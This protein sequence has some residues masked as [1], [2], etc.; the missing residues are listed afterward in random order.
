MKPKLYWIPGTMCDQL[1]WSRTWPELEQEFELVHLTIPT[2]PS[3]DDI[4]MALSAQINESEINLIGFSLGGYLATCLA[5]HFPNKVANLLVI[6]NS[7][8]P[9]PEAEIQQRKQTINWLEKFA[10]RGVTEQKINTMLAASRADDIG[11]KQVI[12]KMEENLGYDTLL[13][14]LKATSNREGKSEFISNTSTQISFCFGDE[15]R[16]VNHTWLTQVAQQND[17]QLFKVENC[18]HMLPL[19]QPQILVSVIRKLFL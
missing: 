3:V 6:S 10:Y 9:L 17:C 13:P 18:G 12:M 5:E 15:D 16:L 19:E 14:Q 8:C 7:P 1:V 2:E 11:L 4:V